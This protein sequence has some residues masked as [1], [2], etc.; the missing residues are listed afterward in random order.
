MG[1]KKTMLFYISL[2][3]SD[4]WVI[5]QGFMYYFVVKTWC[6]PGETPIFV[7]KAFSSVIDLLI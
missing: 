4:N 6:F 7:Q 3:N 5:V 1:D 2:K